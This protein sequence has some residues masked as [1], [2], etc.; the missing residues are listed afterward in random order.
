MRPLDSQIFTKRKQ[1]EKTPQVLPVM[2][3]DQASRTKPRTMKTYSQA[4]SP[5][6]GTFNLRSA[7][8]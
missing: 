5:N 4:L 7:G 3:K 8:F 1:A 6:Q 2:K